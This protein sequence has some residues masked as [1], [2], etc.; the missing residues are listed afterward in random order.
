MPDYYRSEDLAKFTEIGQGAPE[1]W[2][3]FLAWNDSVF[4]AGALTPREKQL[5]AVAVAHALQCPY[6]IDVHTRDGIEAGAT[7]EQLIEAVQ[8]AAAIRA[9]A[10]LAHGLQ[11]RAV[12]ERS[13]T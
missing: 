13:A 1:P 8:V 5:I 11:M 9:G 4:Q 7:G 12:A 6:C 2:K 10:T 3:A